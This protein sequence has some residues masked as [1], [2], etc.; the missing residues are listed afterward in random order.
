[1]TDRPEATTPFD[2]LDV[3]EHASGRLMFAAKLRRK[4]PKGSI[5]EVP[6]RVRVPNPADSTRARID[7]TVFFKQNPTLDRKYDADLFAEIEQM[8]LLALSIRADDGIDFPQLLDREELAEY[9]EASLHEIQERINIYKMLIDCRE[10]DVSEEQ[11]YQ[12]VLQMHRGKTIA[13]LGAMAGPAQL[14]FIMR[15]VGL[16]SSSPGALSYQRHS[17]S[18]TPEP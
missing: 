12:T 13:P 8:A 3:L 11:F 4:K 10:Q 14:S 18:S 1:M 9:D 5:H 2:E 17:E 15:M 16:A 7:A 6:V